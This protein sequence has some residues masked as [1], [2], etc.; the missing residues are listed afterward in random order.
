[1]DYA[2]AEKAVEKIIA[3][4]KSSQVLDA[5]VSYL[6]NHFEQYSWIGIYRV[7]G[8]DLVLGPWKGAHATEHTRIPVGTGICG[9]AAASGDVEVVGDVASDNRY[10]AC[11]CSTRSEIVVPI[12]KQGMVVGEIDIDSDI[13]NVFTQKDSVFL[14]KIAE[15]LS[16][17]L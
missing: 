6:F 1:M 9:A 15:E 10:L 14:Q 13:P 5:V 8:S 4:T 3:E 17:Y 16:R 12:K 11:F 7:E 2:L